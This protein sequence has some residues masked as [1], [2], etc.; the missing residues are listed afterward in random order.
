M[1]T[2]MFLYQKMSTY[3]NLDDDVKYCLHILIVVILLNARAE[4]K[5]VAVKIHHFV[6]L[7]FFV[8]LVCL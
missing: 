3:D 6:R 4:I 2:K 7:S 8:K 5:T 1:K